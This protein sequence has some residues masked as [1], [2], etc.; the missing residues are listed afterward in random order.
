MSLHIKAIL[1][2]GELFVANEMNFGMNHAT[3]AGSIA[4]LVD[5]QSTTSR[6][7]LPHS[8]DVRKVSALTDNYWT[9][10]FIN[11]DAQVWNTSDKNIKPTICQVQI[12]GHM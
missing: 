2:L 5:L 6:Q 7:L 11:Y 3:D 10:D 9:E 1:G 8:L 4:L 12:Y